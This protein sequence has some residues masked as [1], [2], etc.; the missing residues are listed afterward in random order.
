MRHWGKERA[1]K[2][3]DVFTSKIWPFFKTL[4]FPRQHH[5]ARV[6]FMPT[7]D[8]KMLILGSTLRDSEIAMERYRETFGTTLTIMLI[9]RALLGLLLAHKAMSGVQRV[10]QTAIQIGKGNL[11]RRVS[12]QG[13]G[14]EIDT[15]AKAFNKMLDR[16]EVLVN[17]LREVTDNIAHDLRSPLTCIRGI[18]ETTLMGDS[19][20]E[21]F[22]DM[23]TSIIEES[24]RLIEMINSMLEITKVKA[25]VAEIKME[26]VDLN[27]IVRDAVDLFQPLAEDKRIKIELNIP[28]QPV[29]IRGD[30][31]KLQ[32]AIANLLDNAIKYTPSAG[33]VSL[34]LYKEGKNLKLEIADTGIGI[35]PDKLERIFDRF[36][37]GNGSRSAPGSG[38]GLSLALALIKAHDGKITVESTVGKGSKFTV[39][40]PCSLS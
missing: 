1:L 30:K 36:Y 27:E 32:R 33:N 34:S 18:A 19:D 35:P 13:E 11:D 40:L 10:T 9:C 29:F 31:T 37:R 6:L 28:P 7:H 39:I 15:L 24:D 23:T 20:L 2:L 17:E 22:Q 16:I 5:R 38:L 8:G 26:Q 21:D 14:F 4:S 3:N 25:G 12:L